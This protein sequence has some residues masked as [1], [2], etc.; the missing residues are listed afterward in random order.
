[1]RDSLQ[2]P[3][4][5]PPVDQPLHE[6]VPPAAVV[7]PVRTEQQAPAATATEETAY[8]DPAYRE[9]GYREA[10][11]RE[12]ADPA[13][14]ES[15]AGEPAY[16]ESAA[17]GPAYRETAA[18]GPAYRETAASGPVHRE[19]SAAPA[20]PD[21]GYRQPVASD[22]GHREPGYGEPGYR[23]SAYRDPAYRDVDRDGPVSP[24]V[25]TTRTATVSSPGRIGFGAAVLILGLLLGVSDQQA[26]GA[27]M[28]LRIPALIAALIMVAQ[29]IQL[30]LR[31]MPRETEVEVV[32]VVDDSDPTH[33]RTSVRPR[34]WAAQM[35]AFRTDP[36]SAGLPAIVIVLAIWL[37]LA[38]L[39][40]DDA[41]AQFS[42]LSMLSAFVLFALGWTLIPS[43]R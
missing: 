7:A 2:Q 37:G 25:P 22:P 1:M 41:P 19:P 30:I 31:G 23:D 24:P 38:T 43:R 12:P 6:E 5:G 34:P 36:G 26:D 8:G 16:R 20:A 3:V 27:G 28:M 18:G 11:Y 39:R 9:P 17:S 29:G 35:A 21:P 33:A 15:A 13:Y 42:N 14:R 32:E 40:I 4:K 10:G